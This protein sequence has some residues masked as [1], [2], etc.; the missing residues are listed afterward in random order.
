MT[1]RRKLWTTFGGVAAL[2][3]LVAGTTVWATMQWQRTDDVLEEHYLRSLLLQQVRAA[4]FRAFKEVPDA[5]VMRDQDAR[6]EFR[7]AIAPARRDLEEWEA[8]ADTEAER[9]EIAGVRSAFDRVVRESEAFFELIEAGRTQEA[10]VVM[11]SRLE[12]DVFTDFERVTGEAVLADRQRRADVRTATQQVRQTARTVLFIVAFAT[13]SLALLLAAFLRGDLFAPLR[14]IEISMHALA[15]GDMDRRLPEDRADEIGRLEIAFNRMAEA[16]E[17]RERL[18]ELRAVSPRSTSADGG[19]PPY[20]GSHWTANPSRLT[21]HLLVSRLR[22]RIEGLRHHAGNGNGASPPTERRAVEADVLRQIDVLLQSIDRMTEFS[23]PLDLHLMPTDVRALLYDIALGFQAELAAR[24][25]SLELHIAP[26]VATMT[27]DRLKLREVLSELVRN[28]LEALPE[29]GGQLGL[30]ASLADGGATLLLEV[31]DDGRGAEPHRIVR[32]LDL[33]DVDHEALPH[34][35]LR[36]ARAVVE[37]HG[38][39]LAIESEPNE[40]TYVRIRIPVIG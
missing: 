38:G 12:D 10:F 8:L 39:K 18:L 11:E 25:V 5:V 32:A 26:E 27:L 9:E 20:A 29:R 4:V 16:I 1:L 6:E 30:R 22:E 14:E 21:L 17:E 2:A 31:A 35:G 3:L 34:M 33:A 40:G 13:L 23:F 15:H 24:S 37:Q 19:E 7:A 36:L 28:A